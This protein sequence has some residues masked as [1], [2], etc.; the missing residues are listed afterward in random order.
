MRNPFNNMKIVEKA[1]YWLIA[2][3]TVIVVG[4]ILLGV[5]GF[6]KSLD[7]KG[8]VEVKVTAYLEEVQ[9]DV[10]KVSKKVFKQYGLTVDSYSELDGTKDY[11]FVYKFD[12]NA[13]PDGLLDDL[14]AEFESYEVTYGGTTMM[15]SENITEV[16]VELFGRSAS[17][18]TA[19]WA[20]LALSVATVVAFV[21]LVFRYKWRRALTV[22]LATLVSVGLTLLVTAITRI[23]VNP[24]YIAAVAF[25]FV[26]SAI[27]AVVYANKVKETMRNVSF[28]DASRTTIAN[29]AASNCFMTNVILTGAVIVLLLAG[30]IFA[31]TPVKFTLLACL[32][33]ALVSLF[34]VTA[35]QTTLYA[36]I[37]KGGKNK[38]NSYVPKQKTVKEEN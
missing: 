30:I 22:V 25:T 20:L 10:E 27:L 18:S 5:V 35:L 16:D 8:G 26:F 15:L 31:A 33:G 37:G 14:K 4:A 1:K 29:T 23:K 32:V 13:V 19:L 21:Y 6:N 7:Y 36:Y 24:S 3:V 38:K 17:V 34:V 11:S 28:K 12:L 2:L 9:E